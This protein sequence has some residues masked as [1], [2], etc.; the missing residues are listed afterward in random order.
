MSTVFRSELEPNRATRFSPERWSEGKP[1]CNK[2]GFVDGTPLV[3]SEDF[4][5]IGT[6]DERPLHHGGWRVIHSDFTIFPEH[7]PP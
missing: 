5:V 7:F 6:R 2:H 4:M 1:P 3:E